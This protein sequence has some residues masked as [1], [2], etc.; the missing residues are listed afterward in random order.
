MSSVQIKPGM[1]LLSRTIAGMKMRGS[2]EGR[3]KSRTIFYNAM[4]N[5]LEAPV[6]A[7]QEGKLFGWCEVQ[8]P[9]ELFYALDIPPFYPEHY[10]LI[11]A[12]QGAEIPFLEEAEVHH[13]KDV[14]SVQKIFIGAL[15]K[16]E[17]PK[18][19]L[20]VGVTHPCDA[21]LFGMQH[22]AFP[23]KHT[24]CICKSEGCVAGIPIFQLDGP[25]WHDDKAIDYYSGE[26][27]DCIA[28][29][30]KNTGRKM[31]YG[32]L[33][34]TVAHTKEIFDLH[35]ENNQLRK[36]HPTPMRG[37][38]LARQAFVFNNLC[39]TQDGVDYMRAVN[40]E[41]KE[42][43]A[44][45]QGA[46]PNERIRLGWLNAQ[47]YSFL[48][49][50]DEMEREFGAVIVTDNLTCGWLNGDG[51]DGPLF[52]CDPKEPV[53]SIAAKAMYHYGSTCYK[54]ANR[55]SEVVIRM[56]KNYNLDG[57][58]FSA[59]W[60]CKNVCAISK[61]LREDLAKATGVPMLELESDCL[62]QRT[63]PVPK[64]MALTKEFIEMLD[65]KKK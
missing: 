19:D 29:M 7:R 6:K 54:D 37:R 50:L 26:V 16:G 23:E 21:V 36:T 2:K 60:G 53:R 22:V 52:P 47:P 41:M 24:P 38:D 3:V 18:P 48:P 51:S 15:K 39:G 40:A 17:L 58:I 32:K 4:V 45:G 62:D 35:A 9:V 27:Q 57:I 28:F 14:C 13:M 10:S 12:S 64:M 61:H 8:A 55:F 56:A 30:E 43:V 20:M 42:M 44:K 49:Y 46:V 33:E 63:N 34:Q 11:V 25:F 1:D 5:Y 31:D 59:H 65:Q